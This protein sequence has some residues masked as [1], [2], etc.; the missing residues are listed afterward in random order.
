MITQRLNDIINYDNILFMEN[1][2]LIEQGTHNQL[3]NN[4]GYYYDLYMNQL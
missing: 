3:M 2:N 4:K 1:G